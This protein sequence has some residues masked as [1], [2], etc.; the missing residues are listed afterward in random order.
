MKHLLTVALGALFAVSAA[1][2]V[3]AQPACANKQLR[4]IV[5]TPAGGPSDVAARHLAQAL[6]KS[7]GYTFVVDNKPGASGAVAAQALMAAA[8]DGCTLMWTLSSMSGLPALLKTPP[9]QSLAELTA[10]SLVGHLTYAMFVHPDVP[11][12]SVTEFVDYAGAHPDKTSYATGTLGDYMATTKFLKATGVRSVRVPYKG[13]TQLMPDLITGRVQL[14]LGPISTGLQQVRDGKLRMLAVLLPKRSTLAPDVPTMAEV[15]L[16]AV[17]LP[18]WQAVFAPAGTSG[19]VV[20]QLARSIGAA[21]A[22][23]ALREQLEQLAI[24]VEASTPQKLAAMAER[25]TQAWRT[26][27]SEYAIANE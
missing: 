14:N 3:A 2:P 9:Y 15:G 26:F 19:S 4:L 5:P 16:P 25:D 20:D 10:V 18:T 24:Q 8:N 1:D 11:A 21:L 13:A 7:M 23:P 17:V 22:Q 6:S 12:K 27:V